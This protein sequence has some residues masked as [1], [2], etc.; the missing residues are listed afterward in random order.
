MENDFCSLGPA[1]VS[2]KSR[3]NVFVTKDFF[4]LEINWNSATGATGI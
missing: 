3:L 4:Q 2:K 1:F